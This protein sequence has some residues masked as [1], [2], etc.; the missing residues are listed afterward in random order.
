MRI[1][2]SWTAVAWLA[3]DTFRQAFASG[4]G[5]LLLAL[6]GVC[7]VV[8]LSV[9]VSAPARLG[10]AGENPDFLPR[11]DRDAH[12]GQKVRQS[13]VA[14]AD[15]SLRLAFGAIRVPI[16]RNVAGAVHFLQ[17]ILAAGVADTL[18]LLLALVW[19][20]GFLPSFL[21]SRAIAVLLAKPISREALL[22]GKYLGVLAFVF[23]QAAFFVG[24]TWLALAVR[25]GV[26]DAVYL[27]RRAAVA[28]PFRHLLQ[29][30]PAPGRLHAEHGR[31]RLRLDRLLGDLLGDQLR[32]ARRGGRLGVDLPGAFSAPL[33]WLADVGYWLFPKPVD[34]GKLVFD[35]LGAGAYFRTPWVGGAGISL[36]LSVL[37]SLLFTAY[38]LF[39]ASRQFARMDY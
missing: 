23:V 28:A 7:I 24:G 18:G 36:G 25:T 12:D 6:S 14:V 11:F 13:G 34:L 39:A 16:A 22:L 38:I 37:T 31:L 19:T 1:P 9:S 20:A 2:A 5:W 27:A 10:P 35:S 8:C 17:L 3:P 4:I 33:V 30:L 29:L 21:D 15:G 26:W 32:P